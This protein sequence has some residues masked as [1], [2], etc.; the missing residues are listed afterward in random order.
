MRAYSELAEEKYK[1]PRYPVLI[2]IV[3]TGEAEIPT[4]YESNLA[5]LEVRQH[6]RVINLW[7]VYVKALEKPLPSLLPFVP[8]FK[9]GKDECIIGEALHLL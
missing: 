8:I 9:D 3:K 1:L 2:K 4:R 7:V 5:G 6:Y